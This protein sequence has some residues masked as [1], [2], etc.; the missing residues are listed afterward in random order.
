MSSVRQA[1]RALE[2][3]ERSSM[4]DDDGE[5]DTFFATKPARRSQPWR[6]EAEFGAVQS[7]Q[8]L[9][10]D[11]T[12]SEATNAFQLHRPT[13]ASGGLGPK[14]AVDLPRRRAAPDLSFGQSGRQGPQPAKG[15]VVFDFGNEDVPSSDIGD[16]DETDSPSRQKRASPQPKRRSAIGLEHGSKSGDSIPH[17]ATRY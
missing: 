1:L 4:L 17:A 5:D 10:P 13:G 8:H 2:E 16:G 7:E 15:S 11:R 6:R 9:A 14:R 3:E 12:T